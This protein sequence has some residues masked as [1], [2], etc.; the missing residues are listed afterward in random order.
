[1]PTN[2]IQLMARV[3]R[4]G[5]KWNPWKGVL[6]HHELHL[7]ISVGS[8]AEHSVAD[9]FALQVILVRHELRAAGENRL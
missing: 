9:E 1:M 2:L 7:T 3:E 5:W 4:P 8:L 6:E